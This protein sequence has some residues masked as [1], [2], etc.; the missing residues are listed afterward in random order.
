ML[1]AVYEY[2]DANAPLFRA[3]RLSEFGER[4]HAHR[5]PE[6]AQRTN[7]ALEPLHDD[8]DERELRQLRGLVGMLAS[9]DGFE[10]LTMRWG[11]S[12]ADAADAAAWATKVLCERAKRSG[13]AR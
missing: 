11:L 5:A 12:T 8:L 9:F 4:M 6:R 13:V 1:P 2:L 10:V 3:V 7:A